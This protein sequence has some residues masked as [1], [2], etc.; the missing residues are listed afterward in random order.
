MSNYPN[1]KIIVYETIHTGSPYGL[2]AR[3]REHQIRINSIKTKHQISAFPL[4]SVFYQTS[5]RNFLSYLEE[6][7]KNQ[8]TTTVIKQNL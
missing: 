4:V 1:L 2:P 7:A 8:Q 5:F 3:D 6:N